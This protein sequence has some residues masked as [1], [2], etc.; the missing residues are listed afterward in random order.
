MQGRGLVR[1]IA[2]EW[3][4]IREGGIGG[5]VADPGMEKQRRVRDWC[6]LFLGSG[7][8]KTKGKKAATGTGKEITLHIIQGEKLWSLVGRGER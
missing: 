6:R 4:W 8:K 1:M 5:F 3:I 2:R 7:D